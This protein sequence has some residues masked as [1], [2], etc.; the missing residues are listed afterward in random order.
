VKK[1]NANCPHCGA[2]NRYDRAAAGLH[3]S[4]TSCGARFQLDYDRPQRSCLGS[5]L[6]ILLV[7][8]LAAAAAGGLLVYFAGWPLPWDL[9]FLRPAAEV[10][11]A[12]A[13]PVPA[14]STEEPGEKNEAAPAPQAEPAPGS[15]PDSATEPE[16]APEPTPPVEPVEEASPSEP[17]SASEPG[18]RTFELREWVDNSGSFRVTARLVQFAQGNVRLEKENG[19]VIEVPLAR[20]S[21]NDR[22]YVMDLLKR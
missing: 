16:P 3:V 19:D 22:N 7:L 10:A 8:L 4:C 11:E 1:I 9:P 5:C 20:L 2:E 14:P 12:P 21:E 13:Q 17:P 15:E 6:T 18:R